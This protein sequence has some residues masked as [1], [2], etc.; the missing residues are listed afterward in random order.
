MDSG[1]DMFLS[2]PI[3]RP[4]LKQVLRKFAPIPEE[5]EPG[6]LTRRNTGEDEITLGQQAESSARALKENEVPPARS[7]DA[8]NDEVPLQN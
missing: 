3:R 1:M 6:N 7:E 8:T 5:S 4:A 2:K